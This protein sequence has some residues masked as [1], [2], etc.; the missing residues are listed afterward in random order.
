MAIVKADACKSGDF[1]QR[2]SIAMAFRTFIQAHFP[3]VKKRG[4]SD[5]YSLLT[6]GII[7]S[8]GVL[9]VVSF[10]ESEFNVNVADEELIPENFQ[11]IDNMAAFVERKQS[12][13]L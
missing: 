3:V 4:L 1:V 6:S 8:L 13:E 10:M 7:D 5:D 9:D 12:G 11:S 2:E